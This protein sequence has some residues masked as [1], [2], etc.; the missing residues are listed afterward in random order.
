MTIWRVLPGIC[1]FLCM[2]VFA[3]WLIFTVLRQPLY[4]HF[5][6]RL[7]FWFLPLI[8]AAFGLE[9]F[10]TRSHPRSEPARDASLGPGL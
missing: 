3:W 4:A 2:F 5:F 7:G 10:M 6:C 9:Y 1:L 8:P